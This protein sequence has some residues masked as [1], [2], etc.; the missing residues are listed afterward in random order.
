VRGNRFDGSNGG[1]TDIPIHLVGTNFGAYLDRNLILGDPAKP[2]SSG[3]K[4]QSLGTI[5]LASDLVTGASTGLKVEG[6]DLGSL[7][8]ATAHYLTL[9][10][11]ATDISVKSAKLTLTSSIV[12]TPVVSQTGGECNIQ[13]SDGP[14]S[15]NAGDSCQDFVHNEAPGFVDP[16]RATP[17]WWHLASDSPLIDEGFPVTAP[18]GETDIDG[19]PRESIGHDCGDAG[20]E[21]PDIGADEFVLDCKPPTTALGTSTI[22]RSA[23]RATFTFSGA[24]ESGAVSFQCKLDRRSFSKCIS[25]KTY[26]NL[27]NGRHTFQVRS[28]DASGNV[29]TSPAKKAFRI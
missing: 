12:G 6:H 26:R 15:A 17:G 10:G 23:R 14:A 3:I 16:T 27:Q 21:L 24:D 22:R 13:S 7:G 1:G 28:R 19:D 5:V 11:N 18:S 25:R 8:D 20:Y 2:F 9:V 29:D 4:E